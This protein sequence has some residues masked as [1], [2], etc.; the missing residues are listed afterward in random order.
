M[1]APSFRVCKREVGAVRPALSAEVALV[2]A[3]FVETGAVSTRA[4]RGSLRLRGWAGPLAAR[5]PHRR[6]KGVAP[7]AIQFAKSWSLVVTSGVA[8]RLLRRRHG[9]PGT[10]RA[11]PL[12][13]SRASSVAVFAAASQHPVNIQSTSSQHP[14]NIQS[15][16]RFFFII[17]SK[18][19]GN[20]V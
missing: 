13:R 3:V 14:V 11:A 2:S 4:R 17:Y 6:P 8:A 15:T 12:V 18:G 5:V 20:L 7:L 16:S 10:A 9:R 1:G 19:K